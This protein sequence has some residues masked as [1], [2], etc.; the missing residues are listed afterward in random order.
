MLAIMTRFISRAAVHA[1]S[2]GCRERRAP[3]RL[4]VLTSHLIVS[5][6]DPCANGWHSPI[7]GKC[8][9][10]TKEVA[11]ALS[12]VEL[13]G[14]GAAPACIN[15][16]D[17]NTRLAN[18]T[19]EQAGRPISVHTGIYQ[20]PG[21]A[22]YDGWDTC[23]SGE[24]INYSHTAII[25]AGQGACA[26]LDSGGR[27]WHNTWCFMRMRCLCELGANATPAY[28]AVVEAAI[29]ESLESRRAATL[30][31]FLIVIPGV[32]LAP[33]ILICLV[34]AL[35]TH[36]ASAAGAHVAHGGG[37][38]ATT[39]TTTTAAAAALGVAEAAARRRRL[40]VSLATS[41]LGWTLL[42]VALTPIVSWM[43]SVD[44][45]PISGHS[46]LYVALG[47]WGI[48]LLGLLLRP[49]DT[50]A[51]RC[52]GL[53][54]FG[55]CLLFALLCTFL[56]ILVLP[57][58]AALV[59]SI[60]A[61]AL[62]FFMC[63]AL[64]SPLVFCT[65]RGE[66]SGC[67]GARARRRMPPRRQLL[68][69]W[70]VFRLLF[71]GVAAALLGLFFHNG[72]ASD[73]GVAGMAP[74][75]RVDDIQT[76]FLA[77]IASLLLAA[78]VLTHG[79]RGHILRRLNELLSAGGTQTQVA[80]SV[81]A[82]LGKRSA[83]ATLA[84][85]TSRFRALPLPS[86][87]RE[88]L[89]CNRPDPAMHQKTVAA[90]LGGVDAFMSHSWSDDGDAKFDR[91]HAW[92]ASTGSCGGK[93]RFLWLDKV[94]RPPPL[95]AS[96]PL[97]SH[98]CVDRHHGTR[99]RHASTKLPSK[100]RSHACPFSSRA[101]E[102][103]LCLVGAS[104]AS[105]LW[106]VM[107]L[108]TFVRIR[109]KREDIIVELLGDAAKLASSLA[110]FDAGRARCYLAKDRHALLAVIEV[111]FGTFAPFNQLVRELLAVPSTATTL[112]TSSVHTSHQPHTVEIMPE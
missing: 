36:C 82:L 80:A 100:R 86:L 54:F 112:T 73:R 12:C 44:T 71:V 65:P 105:R 6:A 81:A 101:G 35:V 85:A 1:P 42:V 43:I 61:L 84:M 20:Q 59:L 56:F 94:H 107:E 74:T 37:G 24:V 4:L 76:A 88:E 97:L 89:A 104:Y 9:K 99:D 48:A 39:T 69:L 3:L 2:K 45:T 91:L 31:V 96:P 46:L 78:I 64:L 63:T 33:L 57:F 92:A 108:F 55:F 90:N 95:Q 52:V 79:L 75:W 103:L 70:L 16:T 18:F 67:G 5:A 15:S 34:R 32:S 83:A 7:A 62:C 11:S 13:C 28:L 29:E 93:D 51:I 109:G 26:A 110:K 23:A 50:A 8:H 41:Q 106:C 40:R 60:A 72:R 14:A 66:S 27:V 111:A 22:S 102:K 21:S 77:A 87:T 30:L 68:R 19:T 98:L 49:I 10:L 25:Y 38:V 17:E 58:E 53:F 47:P